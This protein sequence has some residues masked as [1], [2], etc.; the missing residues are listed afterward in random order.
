VYLLTF[1]FKLST[2]FDLVLLL[3]FMV[4]SLLENFI[5]MF[6]ALVVATK[7]NKKRIQPLRQTT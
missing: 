5:A 6:F 3:D 4:V 7:A 2:D 1:N